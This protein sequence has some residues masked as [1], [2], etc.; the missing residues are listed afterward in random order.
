MAA[1]STS[2]KVVATNKTNTAKKLMVPKFEIGTNVLK[3]WHRLYADTLIM[4]WNLLTIVTL[5]LIL[6]D[7]F[8]LS[9]TK[10]ITSYIYLRWNCLLSLIIDTIKNEKWYLYNHFVT[11]FWQLFLSYSYMILLSSL[12]L[13]LSSLFLTN[14]NR[15]N[16]GCHH[17][18]HEKDVQIS[19][20]IQKTLLRKNC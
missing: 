16:Q 10:F 1:N 7:S 19:L 4:C 9:L 20:L 15:E 5:Q 17:S 6:K 12:F 13:F 3:C 11:N 2:G 8:Y 18:C 14:K